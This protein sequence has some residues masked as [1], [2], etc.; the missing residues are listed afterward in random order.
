[1]KKYFACLMQ[2]LMKN[3]CAK[4]C[5]R[6]HIDLLTLCKMMLC[7]NHYK[8]IYVLLKDTQKNTCVSFL[9]SVLISG[10]AVKLDFRNIAITI[11]RK[12]INISIVC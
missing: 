4:L 1:M 11:R 3:N 8:H 12:V 2:D 5:A 9:F 6:L 7:F 10:Q